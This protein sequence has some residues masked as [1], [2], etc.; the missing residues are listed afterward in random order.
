LSAGRIGRGPVNEG[1]NGEVGAR[2]QRPCL[3][4]TALAARA[5]ELP[6]SCIHRQTRHPSSHLPPSKAPRLLLKLQPPSVHAL[7]WRS[8]HT[9]SAIASEQLPSSPAPPAAG[10]LLTRLQCTESDHSHRSAGSIVERCNWSVN[11]PSHAHFDS[12]S[13][14]LLS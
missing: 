2:K 5:S 8:R 1:E 7:A 12:A 9:D 13:L 6:F 11:G 4:G 3:I 14:V 10:K